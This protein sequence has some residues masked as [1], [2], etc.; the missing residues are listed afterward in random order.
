MLRPLNWLAP[1]ALIA[2]T[3]L[4]CQLLSNPPGVLVARTPTPTA[5]SSPSWTPTTMEFASPPPSSTPISSTAT[6]PAGTPMPGVPDLNGVWIDNGRPIVIVQNGFNITAAY[7]EERECDHQDGTGAVSRYH[8]DFNATLFQE[9]GAWK[10]TSDNMA[11]CG[12]GYEDHSLNGLQLTMME[13][14]LSE[15]FN[16]IV[17]DWFHTADQRWVVDG[18]SIIRE[19]EGGAPVPTPTGYVLPTALP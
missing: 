11:A 4:S 2:F 9:D 5:T 12:W 6:S 14:V 19:F 8:H 18:V 13:A 17:G 15:D 16:T 10:L 7:I 3:Q 1:F